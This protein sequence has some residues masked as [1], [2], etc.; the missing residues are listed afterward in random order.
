MWLLDIFKKALRK[1]TTSQFIK[2]VAIYGNS[3]LKSNIDKGYLDNA[4]VYS[5]VRRIAKTATTIPIRV[6]KIVNEKSYKDY[7]FLLQQ[8]NYSPQ[9]LLKLYNKKQLAF[10]LVND[11]NNPIQKLLDNPNPIYDKTEF[12]E[13][14]YS[15]RLLTG[16]SYIY[17]YLLEFGADKGKPFEMWLLPPQYTQPVITTSFPH[18]ITGYQLL[19]NEMIEFDKEEILHSRYFNPNFTGY[20]EELIGLSPLKAG[21]KILQRSIDETDYS[22]AAFQNSGISGIVSNEDVTNIN[23]ETQGKL[24]SDFYSEASGTRN[25]RKLLFTNG[26]VKYTQIGLGPVDMDIIN[27]EVRTFKRLCNLFGVS[28]ILFNNSDASTESNVKEMVKQ[29]Y[30]NAALPEVYAFVNTFNQNIVPKFNTGGVKYFVDC[31]L[32]EITVL[33][34]DMKKLAETFAQLPIMIPNFILET[35]GYG[36]QEDPLLDKVYVKN[37]YQPIDDMNIQDLPITGDYGE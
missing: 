28:D 26:K 6:Y 3:S 13:G 31:D 33:Q 23:T 29:L 24:K 22:V 18:T 21:S 15:F 25:A 4:D 35:M 16:N 17:Q 11:N 7:Q 1:T 2:G 9:H 30:V 12:L 34:D 37:G 36:K 20:G 32:T 27:S 19:L 10:E 8:K 5:V 14:F